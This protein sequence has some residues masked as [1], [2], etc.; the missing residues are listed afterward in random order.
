MCLAFLPLF[1]PVLLS[2]PRPVFRAITPTGEGPFECSTGFDAT[3]SASSGYCYIVDMGKEIQ[4]GINI[5]FAR[6]VAGQE[7]R[8]V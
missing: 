2:T 7:V 1:G 8:L 5:T 4:G 6:G 3:G